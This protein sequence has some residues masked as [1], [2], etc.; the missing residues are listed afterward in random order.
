MMCQIVSF[1]M[2]FGDPNHGFKVTVFIEGDCLKK[3]CVLR[4]KFL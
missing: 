3:R 1:S 2:S 4:T